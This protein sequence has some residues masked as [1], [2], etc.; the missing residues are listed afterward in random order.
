MTDQERKRLYWIWADMKSRC[1]NANHKAYPNYGG[2]GITVCRR[3]E[4][5]E[6]FLNDMAPRPPKFMLD[7]IDNNGGYSP[8][9]C[10][11]ASRKTQNS[12]R[13][14]CIYVTH[15]GSKVTLKEFCRQEGLNYRAIVK[16]IQDRGWSFDEAIKTPIGERLFDRQG[17][18]IE[19]R[20]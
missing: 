2:R 4:A 10:R 14:N 13:R 19:A 1:S 20:A 6:N 7:R 15:N 17:N 9:N 5:F 11:W 18:R 12:N 16:R 3:W 8:Q